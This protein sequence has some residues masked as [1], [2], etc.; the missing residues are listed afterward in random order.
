M[1]QAA[2][3]TAVG[4]SIVMGAACAAMSSSVTDSVSSGVAGSSGTCTLASAPAITW[5]S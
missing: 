4:S 3:E 1:T 2:A 5:V